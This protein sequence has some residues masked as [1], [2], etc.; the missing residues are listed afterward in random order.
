M[1]LA[2]ECSDALSH[3]LG[4]PPFHSLRYYLLNPTTSRLKRSITK[5]FDASDFDNTSALAPNEA[6][7]LVIFGVCGVYLYGY[8]LTAAPV[9]I[10]R[11]FFGPRICAMVFAAAAIIA[12]NTLPI[13][14]FLL[15]TDGGVWHFHRELDCSFYVFVKFLDSP[16]H[17]WTT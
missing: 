10:R 1:P 17:E 11:Y 3:A 12:F 2:K 7:V 16:S 8:T 15:R 6:K 5:P 9:W 14:P 13:Y 4:P